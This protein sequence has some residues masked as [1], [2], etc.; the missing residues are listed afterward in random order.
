MVRGAG[1]RFR[2]RRRELHGA[3]RSE[4]VPGAARPAA[5]AA[6]G[7]RGAAA[8]VSQP[9]GR[10]RAGG[11]GSR[12]CVRA[13]A[14]AEREGGRRSQGKGGAFPGA[15]RQSPAGGAVTSGGSGDVRRER[16]WAGLDL[17]FA[18]GFTAPLLWLCPPL[19]VVLRHHPRER[20]GEF[21][22]LDRGF[23]PVEPWCGQCWDTT[24]VCRELC[25]YPWLRWKFAASH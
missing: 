8:A 3:G 1:A 25:A 7:E 11:R 20:L 23:Y 24:R 4:R 22:S 14:C 17:I 16:G 15:L 2:P 6:Q 10:R 12:A 19:V 9:G 18:P 5:R 21:G 13:R